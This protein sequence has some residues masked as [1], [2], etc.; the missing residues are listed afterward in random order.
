M[1]GQYL[2]KRANVPNDR[3]G[4]IDDRENTAISV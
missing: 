4:G 3:I 1:E 2:R